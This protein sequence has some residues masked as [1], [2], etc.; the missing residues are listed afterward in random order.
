MGSEF[1]NAWIHNL[2]EIGYEFFNRAKGL[3]LGCGSRSEYVGTIRYNIII[4]DTY[5]FWP[6]NQVMIMARS[7]LECLIDNH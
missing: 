6:A 5:L 2:Y 7:Y 1:F 3:R 4:T